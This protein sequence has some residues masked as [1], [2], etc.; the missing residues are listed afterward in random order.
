MLGIGYTLNK[1]YRLKEI[2]GSGGSATVYLAYDLILRRDV[3]VKVLKYDFVNE[4]KML[5]RFQREAKL[6]S[7]VYHQNIVNLYDVDQ[8]GQYSYLV[9]EYIE[10][11]DL[12]QYIRDNG[13]L[14]TQ[15]V[16]HIMK[17]IVSAMA[18]A[19]K[20]GIIHR[21]LKT[22]NILISKDNV[23]KITD[24][25]IA[26]GLNEATL[27]QTNTLVGSIH[28]LSPE[29]ARGSK[30]TIQSDVY[31]LGIIMYELMSGTVPFNGDT[32]VS[33]AMKHFQ[34]E[35]PDI[36][37]AYF[38][39]SI[40]NVMLKALSKDPNCRYESC[41]EM[42]LALDKS[43]Q[44]LDKRI[45]KY[46][47]VSLKQKKQ[48]KTSTKSAVTPD[49]KK[50]ILDQSKPKQTKVWKGVLAGLITLI[51]LITG[52][53]LTMSRLYPVAT[54]IT[55]PN[56]VNITEQEAVKLLTD[57]GLI[58]DKIERLHDNH[59]DKDKVIKINPSESSKVDK[60]SKVILY[61][62]L[63]SDEITLSDYTNKAYDIVY[64]DLLAQGFIVERKMATSSTVASGNIISQSISAGT[65]I[66]P[67][68]K[69]IILTVSS[70]AVSVSDYTNQ[71]YDTVKKTL[72]SEGF[73]VLKV[74]VES[75]LDVGRIVSQNVLAGTK[76]DP[77][78]TTITFEVS[79]GVVM[80]NLVG[81]TKDFAIQELAKD[82]IKKVTIKYEYSLKPTGTVISQSIGSGTFISSTQ[83]IIL[84]VSQGEAVETTTMTTTMTETTKQ[85]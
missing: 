12:K 53:L 21:D 80:P 81:A 54:Q 51:V 49:N 5:Q 31:S 72:E 8:D 73:S 42:L 74:D 24:F 40:T 69:T 67:K 84:T 39:Q 47:D 34:N 28:Y 68:G 56:V 30:A 23:V 1:R 9:M 75:R 41:D 59:V 37:S 19:H 64:N 27:T 14:S 77:A 57:S 38:P 78:T 7:T 61:V 25:G 58:V 15:S 65:K 43:M 70:G 60:N 62:S 32:A 13:K 26:T 2:I 36:T 71:L 10:G 82:N 4:E 22:Q 63:G 35:V 85:P 55:I 17:Q 76:V 52:I 16:Y 79:K 44:V 3:A 6:I 45:L 11:K 20:K 48:E 18:S 50:G 83:E 46:V 66:S 33:I 29:L